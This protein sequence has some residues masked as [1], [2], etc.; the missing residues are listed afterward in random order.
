MATA[1]RI[2]DDAYAL[3][4]AKAIGEPLPAA[5]SQYALRQLNTLVSVW[6]LQSMTT[7]AVTKYIFPLVANQQ[8]YYI[9]PGQQWNAPRPSPGSVQAVTLLYQGLSSAQPLVSLTRSGHTATGTLVAHGL[10]AGDTIVIYGEDCDPAYNGQQVVAS[11]PTADTF[12]YPILETPTSPA[13]GTVNLYTLAPSP[14]QNL[15]IPVP[16]LSDAAYQAIQLKAM[17][18]PLFTQCYYQAT[19]PFGTF[20]LWPRPT[21]ATNQIVLYVLQS[22]TGFEDLTTDYTW[23]DAAGYYDALQKNLAVML[24]PAYPGLA[25]EGLIGKMAADALALV[26]RSNWRLVDLANDATAAI[27]GTR[28]GG[29]NINTNNM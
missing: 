17:G 1:L 6:Q 9:G 3:I 26:K 27:N 29:Y 15:E 25:N 10:A 13:T 2:I 5:L 7:L 22:F 4:G 11:V 23:A 20:Y 16:L 12:T 24:L 19:Q 18:N 14:D 8:V 28:L 21:T